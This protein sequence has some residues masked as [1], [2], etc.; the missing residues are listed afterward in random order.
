[1]NNALGIMSAKRLWDT[2][3]TNNNF[4]PP[5]VIPRQIDAIRTSRFRRNF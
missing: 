2:A 1:L 5:V 4:A 3:F